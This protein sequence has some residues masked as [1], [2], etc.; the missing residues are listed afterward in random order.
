MSERPR[1]DVRTGPAELAP[2]VRFARTVPGAET[3][4]LCFHHAGGAADTYRDWPAALAPYGIE[5]WP[6]QL[7][8]R[9]PRFSEPVPD[10]LDALTTTLWD[11]LGD[12]LQPGRYALYGLSAGA[13]VAYAF[14]VRGVLAGYPPPLGLF[15]VGQRPAGRPDPDHPLHLLAPDDFQRKVRSFG[16]LPDEVFAHPDLLDLALQVIRA[17]LRLIETCDRTGWPLLDCPVTV[18]AGE[19]DANVPLDV[20]PAWQEITRRPVT[21]VA[22]PGGHFPPPVAVRRLRGVV[23]GALAAPG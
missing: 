5:V 4:L 9:G 12:R 14:A 21:T 13:A 8:G 16:G 6:I 3:R 2:W 23:A 7:P 19:T 17:D 1:H 22:L 15:L 18:A 11:V 20:L 10:D